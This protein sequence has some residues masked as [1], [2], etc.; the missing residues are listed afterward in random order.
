MKT[1]PSTDSRFTCLTG[2]P[3]DP[4]ITQMKPGDTVLHA[5][6]GAFIHTRTNGALDA[7]L[8]A[9]ASVRVATPGDVAA[10]RLER[11][12]AIVTHH[13]RFRS[14][15]YFQVACDAQGHIVALHAEQV[16][17]SADAH[18]HVTVSP[19]APPVRA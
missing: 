16:A 2:A 10:Y 13:Y 17:L 19:F 14:G 3:E 6:T 5:P 7:T 4:A 11:D 18:G 1:D 15:G 8:P 12:P 9:I